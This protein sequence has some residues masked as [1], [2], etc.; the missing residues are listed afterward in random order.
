MFGK[1]VGWD[2]NTNTANINDKGTT[3]ITNTTPTAPAVGYSRNNPAP[4]GVMQR[5]TVADYINNYTAEVTVIETIRGN[6]AWTRI[7]EANMYNDE[8]KSDEEYILAKIHVKAVTIAG[9]KKLSIHPMNFDVYNEGNTMYDYTSVVIPE[10][11]LVTDLFSGAEHTGY[12]VYK[13]KKADI[14]PKIVYGDK[15]DGTGGIWFK[16]Q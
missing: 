14:N 6:G 3:T 4:I 5:V 7:K 12:A 2:G 11:S 10:P 15:Y 1:D 8:P 16:L 9:D 13:V